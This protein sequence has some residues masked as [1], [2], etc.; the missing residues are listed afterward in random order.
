MTQ[1]HTPGYYDL[2]AD[3]LTQ[4]RNDAAERDRLKARNAELREALEEISNYK[5]GILAPEHALLAL[6]QRARIAI[7]K[8]E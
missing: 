1:Q 5:L 8:G 4:A 3:A 7:A 6:R 2:I